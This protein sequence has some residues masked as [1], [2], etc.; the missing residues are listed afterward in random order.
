MKHLLDSQNDTNVIPGPTVH[1]IVPP[2]PQT[3]YARIEDNSGTCY[4]LAQ[5]D[6]YFTVANAGAVP[7]PYVL[8]DQDED[9]VEPID[10][11]SE[12]NTFVLN[13]EDPLQYNISYHNS[14]ADADANVNQL[15]TPYFVSVPGETI[16]IRLENLD[17]VSCYDTTTI[18]VNVD[19]PPLINQPIPLV[20]CDVDNDGFAEFTLHD[21]DLDITGWRSGFNGYLSSHSVG[22]R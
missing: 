13:G 8:C 21:A 3:I 11:A 16:Y 4:D 22:C 17:D 10:L 15:P 1:L 14:Q 18:D 19:S 5:F 20:V 9:G 12:F 7:S 2:S 6:I